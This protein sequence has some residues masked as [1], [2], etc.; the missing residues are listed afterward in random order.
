MGMPIAQNVWALMSSWIQKC[1]NIVEDFFHLFWQLHDKL[2]QQEL[3]QWT[4]MTW[5]IWN[6]RNKFYFEHIQL[7]PKI[8]V[9]VVRGLLEEY[10]RLMALQ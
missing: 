10:Q 4:A 8:I 2:S 6:A 7:Q 1:R 3:D 9:E 5:S